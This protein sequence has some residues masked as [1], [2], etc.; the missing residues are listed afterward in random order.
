MMKN[1]H[2]QLIIIILVTSLAMSLIINYN[3]NELLNEYERICSDYENICNNYE[4]ICFDLIEDVQNY[5]NL[6]EKV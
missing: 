1:I 3:Q 6:I 4:D 5:Q 2:Y